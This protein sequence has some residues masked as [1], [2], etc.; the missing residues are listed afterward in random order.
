MKRIM[1]FVFATLLVNISFTQ[2]KFDNKPYVE[3]EMLVQMEPNAS[4]YDVIKKFPINLGLEVVE[5]LSAPMRIWLV[6]YD[7][8]VSSASVIQKLLYDDAQISF[9]EY[10]YYV[11]MRETVPND[12]QLGQQWHHVNTG[13]TGGTT[14]AD[15]DSDLAWDITT[16][17]TTAT[18]DDIVVCLIEGAN[19]D[20][21]DL[22]ANRWINP[23]EIAGNGIDDDGN[24]YVD[25][26]MGWNPGGNNGTIGYG[27]NSGATSHGTNCVGM[28]AAIGNN[29]LGVVGA[30]WN[31]KVMVVTYANT[32]Q[33][34]VISAYTYPLIQRQRWNNSNGTE[35]ALVVATSASWGIDGANPNNYPLWCNFYDTLGHYGIINIGA[36][37]N[38]NLNVDVSGDM[39]TAC[40]SP[41]MVG[42][43]RTDHNDNTAGGY[44]ATT[45]ELG[46]PGINVR[47][48]ANSNGYTTTTGTSFACPLTAGIVGLAYAIP[49]E[50]FINFVKSDPQGG[51][52][53]VLQALLEG[54]DQKTQLAT[55][56]ITGGRLNARNTL[57][58]LMSY[59]CNLSNCLTPSLDTIS[60]VTE[61]SALL[62]WNSSVEADNFVLSFREVGA[63]AWTEEV[64]IGSSF[65]LSGLT[66]C[67]TYEYF[68]SANCA[69]EESSNTNIFTFTTQ[70]CGACLDL[71]YCVGASTDASQNL[72]TVTQPAVIADNYTFQG[73]SAWGA[74]LQNTYASGEMVLV[75][76][77]TAADSLG[78]NALVNGADLSGKIA[79]VFRGTCQFSIKALNAQNAGAIGVILI[80]NVAGLIDMA[81]GA[82]GAS[83]TIPVAMISNENG[84][85]LKAQLDA[86]QTL[87]GILGTKRDWISSVSVGTF[88]HTSANDN[89]YAHHVSAGTIELDQGTIYP[90]T[91]SPGY[92]TQAYETQFRAWIDFDQN[93]DFEDTELI[94][95]QSE[96][97]Y[98]NVSGTFNIPTN[99]PLGSTRMRVLMSYVGP[100]QSV[101]PSS[102]SQFSFGEVEDYCVEIIENSSTNSI[103]EIGAANIKLFPNPAKD[104]LTISNSSELT[105]LLELLDLT[106]RVV[107][108]SQLNSGNNELNVGRLATGTF[109]YRLTSLYGEVV[110]TGKLQI[111]R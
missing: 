106:G 76:D 72:F 36:T 18:G 9:S 89:G 68:L 88:I 81:T 30:N 48:T 47:T 4:I 64:V 79:V 93:G 16:G 54:V 31:L 39:P 33:A 95:S 86:G 111:T 96:P 52:D 21:D 83:V 8:Q 29:N 6:K 65:T 108:S 66:S 43:G 7:Q 102:C 20:H 51:A 104:L 42:V 92:Q 70:G 55:R 23:G 50:S 84:A 109:I 75:S 67:T 2:S 74:N 14:D 27:T 56:F 57:D 78:C 41:Y 40:S 61:T 103:M 28:F 32:T 97:L 34:S 15:I 37:T 44:G 35:G 19:L 73:P 62:S 17:G 82:N 98:G 25:D 105:V 80:N 12:T 59:S 69:E 46:A 87:R 10:N 45:I 49:C 58:S 60:S 85:V 22:R 91:F 100:G 38:S 5:E 26:I 110:K 3:G 71:V 94:Y 1:L 90:F 13:Q 63:T 53:L 99:A 24:G 107:S 101:L 77:G 11:E